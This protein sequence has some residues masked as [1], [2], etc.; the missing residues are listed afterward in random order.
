MKWKNKKK[1]IFLIINWK[2]LKKEKLIHINNKTNNI[3]YINKYN[4]KN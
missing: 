2:Y 3:L 1:L 4:I